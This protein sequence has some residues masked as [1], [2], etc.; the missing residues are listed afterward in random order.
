MFESLQR[1]RLPSGAWA[2]LI[3][4]LAGCA[5]H[6]TLPELPEALPST[7]ILARV[8]FFPDD[9]DWCG[10]AALASSL[11]WA[12]Q[13]VSPQELV[14]HVYSPAL[15]GSLPLDLIGATRQQGLIPFLLTPSLSALLIEVAHDHPVL[16]LQKIGLLEGSWHY[17]VVIGYDLPTQTLWLHSGTKERLSETFAEFEKSWR[18]GGNWALVITA[19]GTVPASATENTY[20]TQIVPLEN[21]APNL[22]AQGYHNALT[23]WP[24]SYRAWMGLGALAFQAHRYPEALVDYQ[25]VTRAHPLEGDAFNNLA[26]TWRALGN[27]PAAREAITKA[28]SLGDVHRSLY[29]KTLKEIN[30]TQEK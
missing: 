26:E 10:P 18:P 28:L 11:S 22:A 7:V 23:R 13:P 14:P 1:W 20:L 27:L 3:L 6:P 4:L 16:I 30:E 9:K 25:E 29:E 8:P 24:E 2:A 17:A 5:S 15:H 21:F 19:A 12:G